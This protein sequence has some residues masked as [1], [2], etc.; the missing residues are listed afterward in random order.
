M[1][2]NFEIATEATVVSV[3]NKATGAGAAA[4]M[5]GFVANINWLG[6]T[7]AFVAL[8]GFAVSVY[9][10]IRRDKREAEYHKERLKMLQEGNGFDRA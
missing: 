7:G 8:S 3:A 2:S 10:Q 1:A 6:L 4:G 9:F 5:A